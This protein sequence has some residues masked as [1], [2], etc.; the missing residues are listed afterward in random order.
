LLNRQ[1][2]TKIIWP[3]KR[4]QI[5]KKN[6]KRKLKERKGTERNGARRGKNRGE[7]ASS[8]DYDI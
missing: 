2:D 8:G 7:E 5:K 6:K 4:Q 1:Q 3:E